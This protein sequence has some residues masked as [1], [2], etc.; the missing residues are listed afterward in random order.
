MKRIRTTTYLS[1]TTPNAIDV[2]ELPLT[3]GGY[4]IRP[5]DAKYRDIREAPNECGIYGWYSGDGDLMYVGRS[6]AIATRLRQHR[7]GTHF[8]G[9]EPAYFSFKLVPERFVAGVEVAHIRTLEPPENTLMESR[10]VPFWDALV[11]AIDSIWADDLPRQRARLDARYTE[12]A[13]QI[14]RSL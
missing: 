13:E 5:T 6:V 7:L 1:N 14:A 9:G 10:S 4:I 11:A 12:L 8:M 3:W 2:A